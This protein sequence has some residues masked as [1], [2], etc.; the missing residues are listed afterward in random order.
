MNNEVK[1]WE[2]EVL[3]D[4]SS[5]LNK[6]DFSSSLNKNANNELNPLFAN[7][8]QSFQDFFADLQPKNSILS[9]VS[10]KEQSTWLTL[11]K[12]TFKQQIIH[13]QLKNR[14]ATKEEFENFYKYFNKTDNEILEQEDYNN[15]IEYF[16]W[17]LNKSD[18]EVLKSFLVMTYRN[19]FWYWIINDF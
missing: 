6:S 1:E 9:K 11:I 17:L 14:G 5:S 3:N 15:T 18:L 10:H 16:K 8:K 2:I 12:P 13:E 4:F 7:P 19:N